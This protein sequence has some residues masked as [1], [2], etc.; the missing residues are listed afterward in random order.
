M[1]KN[2]SSFFYLIDSKIELLAK[3]KNQT[4][5]NQV[6]NAIDMFEKSLS[7]QGKIFICGNGGSAADA[8]HMAAELVGKFMKIRRAIPAIAITTDSS[9]LTS[10]G[11]D[12]S[13][14]KI[15]SRQLEALMGKK[16]ILLAIT[17]SGKSKNIIEAIKYAKK[18]KSK[19]ICLTS[20]TAPHSL[21]KICDLV[22]RVPAIRVD[23][24]QELHLFIEHYI[25]QKLEISSG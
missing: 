7:N 13:F 22:L 8:Q 23:R 6:N 18:N 5:L 1:S 19:V 16:D 24:I 4:F 14:Q 10:L 20:K 12:L 9:V 2:L 15:F 11:N 21:N 3:I 17:T 25:C